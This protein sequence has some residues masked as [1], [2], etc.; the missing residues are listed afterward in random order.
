VQQPVAMKFAH[1]EVAVLCITTLNSLMSI[2]GVLLANA[3][4][5]NVG[6]AMDLGHRN[7]I[8]K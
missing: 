5:A 3:V 4:T 7:T 2:R 8:N 6:Q 1:H